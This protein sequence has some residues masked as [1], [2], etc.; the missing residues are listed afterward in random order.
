[1]TTRAGSVAYG[2][3]SIWMVLDKA[4]FRRDGK[5][6]EQPNAEHKSTSALAGTRGSRFL[7]RIPSFP[8][9]TPFA[10]L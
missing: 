7:R 6:G 10:R 3:I 2:T 8:L 5:K 1:V 9:A 4:C